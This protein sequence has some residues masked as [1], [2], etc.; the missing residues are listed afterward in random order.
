[1]CTVLVSYDKR[2]KV[3]TQVIELLSV[4]KGVKINYDFKEKPQKNGLDEAIEDIKMG[5]TETYENFD[6]FKKSVYKEL[7]HV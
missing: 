1:M 3:A 5:R 4:I 7:G 6:E 2:N